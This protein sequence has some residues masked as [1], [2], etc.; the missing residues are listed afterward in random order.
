VSALRRVRAKVETLQEKATV[1]FLVIQ[2]TNKKDGTLKDLERVRRVRRVKAKGLKGTVGI[3]A[4]PATDPV[5]VGQ[6][7][8]SPLRLRPKQSRLAEFGSW[9]VSKRPVGIHV[10]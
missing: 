7:R 9:H 8:K 6:S 2:I 5:I 1:N 4:S 10:V 3:V